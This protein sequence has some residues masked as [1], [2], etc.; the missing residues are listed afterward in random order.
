VGIIAHR[1]PTKGFERVLTTFP[2]LSLAHQTL[3]L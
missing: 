3:R 2:R 1:V